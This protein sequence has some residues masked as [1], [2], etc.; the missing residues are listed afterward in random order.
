[1]FRA[2]GSLAALALALSLATAAVAGGRVDI[3][4]G[5]VPTKLTAR[6][7]FDVPFTMQYPNG[8]PVKNAKPVVIAR[9]GSITVESPA[10]AGAVA[11]AYVAQVTLPNQGAWTF[12]ID[13]KICGNKCALAPA[14][15][16]AAVV[17]AKSR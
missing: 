6:Q 14:T 9:C 3:H 7:A 5:V 13:S 15:A 16:M 4:P 8:S 1:M 2:P 17:P 12:E 11:G 10:K